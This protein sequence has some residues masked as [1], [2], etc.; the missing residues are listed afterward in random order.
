MNVAEENEPPA[1]AVIARDPALRLSLIFMLEACGLRG[2]GVESVQEMV[3]ERGFHPAVIFIDC[4]MIGPQEKA[5][6]EQL[7]ATDWAGTLIFMAE[8]EDGWLVTERSQQCFVLVKP[9]SSEDVIRTIG[10]VFPVRDKAE[11]TAGL[12]NLSSSLTFDGCA[13]QGSVIVVDDRV[14]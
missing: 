5:L 1:A 13:D 2:L 6:M 12:G 8:D 3:T 4:D 7:F 9:F 14:W 11:A 10:D